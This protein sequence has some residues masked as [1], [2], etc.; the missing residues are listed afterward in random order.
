MKDIQIKVMP[1]GSGIQC[2]FFFLLFSLYD[3]M[4]FKL[5]CSPYLVLSLAALI[6][7]WVL[8]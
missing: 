3:D 7:I 6:R 4:M 1:L 8:N 5:I 2:D